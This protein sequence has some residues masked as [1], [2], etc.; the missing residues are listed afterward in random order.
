MGFI[1][2]GG[3]IKMFNTKYNRLINKIERMKERL[4]DEIHNRD[5]SIH[6]S[7][8]NQLHKKAT[9]VTL[10]EIKCNVDKEIFKIKLEVLNEIL[11]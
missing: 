11:K 8:M 5:M 4:E 2:L 9:K 7:I 10:T 1:S 6:Q 3:L